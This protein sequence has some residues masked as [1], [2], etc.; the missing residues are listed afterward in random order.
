MCK[1]LIGT[2]L[3]LFL[4]V[5]LVVVIYSKEKNDLKGQK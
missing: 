5:S 1:L 2:A 3:I 4:L